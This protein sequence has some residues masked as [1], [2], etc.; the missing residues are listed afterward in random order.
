VVP[1]IND[2]TWAQEV[3][4]WTVEASKNGVVMPNGELKPTMLPKTL[5]QVL[6]LFSYGWSM[7]VETEGLAVAH[8]AIT[9]EW[10]EGW[11]EIGGVVTKKEYR[12]LGYASMAVN[13]L[14]V[15]VKHN[16]PDKKLFALCNSLSLPLFI[17]LGGVVSEGKELPS[18]VWKECE[19]CSNFV[20]ARAAGKLCCDTPVNMTLADMR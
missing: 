16:F 18:E 5:E 10:P 13:A 12:K 6:G 11:L 9:F 20:R 14:M 7:I 2:V 4:S 8:A 17:G 15:M 1:T 19:N 3:S